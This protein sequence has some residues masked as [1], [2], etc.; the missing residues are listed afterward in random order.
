MR[1]KFIFFISITFLSC[2]KI[3]IQ[4]IELA[5]AIINEGERMH[6]LNISL[7]NQMFKEKAEKIDEFIQKEYTP[8][9]IDEFKKKI[10]DNIDIKAEL[11]NMLMSIIPVITS[12]RDKMQSTLEEQRIKLTTKLNDDYQKFKEAT[13]SL[14]SLL[15]STAKLKKEQEGFLNKLKDTAGIKMDF[16][17]IENSI[18]KFIS[19]SGEVSENAIELNES[20]NNIIKK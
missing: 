16:N 13:I 15:V 11:P 20:I 8:Q 19:K 12:R 1:K 9:F 3:P 6:S 18:D 10:P 4:S 14:K 2:A 5:D 17:Q 7:L